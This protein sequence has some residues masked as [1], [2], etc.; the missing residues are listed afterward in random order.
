MESKSNISIDQNKRY[1]K[2]YTDKIYLLELIKNNESNSKY[3][4]KL[5]GSTKNVYEIKLDSKS[6]WCDCPDMKSYAHKKN[7]IC[8]HCCFV[9][10]KI[11]KYNLTEYFNNFQNT[12]KHNLELEYLE[13]KCN[14]INFGSDI[15]NSSISNKYNEI[16]NSNNPKNKF[17]QTKV[18]NDEDSCPICFDDFIN[19]VN[20]QCPTCKNLIHQE[21]MKKW[22]SSGKST[23]VYCR[24]D[25][26][27]TFGKEQSQEYVNL[28]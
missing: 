28:A 11:L 9:L 20:L 19:T 16:K 14:N 10:F 5:S 6:I 13:D 2:I 21:C 17:E 23:C 1:N 4:F 25:S 22:I 24:S 12:G 7:I 8:K 18:V 26:W 15:Q 27:Q 3:I